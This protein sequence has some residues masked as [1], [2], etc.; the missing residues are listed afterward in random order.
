MTDRHPADDLCVMAAMC[1]I[2]LSMA[3]NQEVPEI[4]YLMQAA[5]MLDYG[6]AHSNS[7]FQIR[8][9]LTRLLQYLGCGVMAMS[10][11]VA[12][13]LKQI[14][15]DTLSYILFDRI[16]SFHPHPFTPLPDD[17]QEYKSP[18]DTIKKQHKLYRTSRGHIGKNIWLSFKNGSYNSI[19]ELK[20]VSNTLP[21]TIAAATSVVETRKIARFLEPNSKE[22]LDEG[23]DIIRKLTRFPFMV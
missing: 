14:Q 5:T 21:R 15:L 6:T 9:L 7:N 12:L 19:F 8:L 10:E 1:L 11:Y 22:P 2:K 3:K 23:Y 20:E 13:S 16:S 18:H 17:D 4:S